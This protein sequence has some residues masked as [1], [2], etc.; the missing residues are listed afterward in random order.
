[1]NEPIADTVRGILDGHM[2]L[3][4]ALAHQN[5]YPALDI[6]SSISRLMSQ[7][8]T[9]EHRELA[10]QMR[11]MMALY[12]EN[13]ELIQLGAYHRGNS[14]EL[15]RAVDTKPLIEAFLKQEFEE[16]SPF[17]TTEHYLRLCVQAHQGG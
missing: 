9:P 10:R 12:K 13:K 7:L 14:A 8:A 15:D 3:S 17:E 5:H 6:L 1:M 16:Y 11:T 4:R 2:V